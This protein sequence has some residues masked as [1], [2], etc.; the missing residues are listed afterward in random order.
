MDSD[1]R[2]MAVTGVLK[3]ASEVM[4]GYFVSEETMNG[5]GA[6]RGL[7]TLAIFADEGLCQ[8]NYAELRSRVLL[9]LA[10]IP[11]TQE[12]D[13]IVLNDA[14]PLIRYDVVQHSKGIYCSSLTERAA[15]EDVAIIDYL[16]VHAIEQLVRQ[17]GR[18]V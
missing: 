4:V 16:D 9:A 14:S 1:E 13:V 6:L 18:D 17:D 2:L 5:R 7:P 8:G 10:S 11:G 15:F 12:L 3:G